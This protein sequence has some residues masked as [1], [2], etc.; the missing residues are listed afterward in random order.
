MPRSVRAFAEPALGCAGSSSNLFGVTPPDERWLTLGL[1][2]VHA[3]EM[4]I[5]WYPGHMNTAR[6]E[7]AAALP[8]KD[9]LIEVLDARMPVASTN[10]VVTELRGNKPCIKILNK[11]DLAD[12]EVTKSWIRY[13]ES[14][15]ESQTNAGKVVAIA[16]TRTRPSETRARIPELCKRLAPHRTGPGKSVRA[17]VVGIPNVGKSTLINTLM[18][19][20]VTRVADV[21]AVTKQQLLIT[22]KSGMTL[23]DNPGILWPRMDHTATLRLAL[24]GAIPDTAMDYESVAIFAAG[25]FLQRYPRL[26]CARFHLAH[27]PS[28]PAGVLDVIA[29]RHGCLRS[30][31]GVDLYKAADILVHEFRAGTLGR[32]SLEAPDDKADATLDRE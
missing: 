22:L 10:P 14:Q 4:S 8:S 27:V 9:V 6:R 29:K 2:V 1:S 28:S 18:E 13:F 23:S 21:P 19:R 3:R 25:F 11:S 24:G 17:M 31:G 30:G 26:L 32:I 7:I 12:P 20:K 15:T 16:I 5:E